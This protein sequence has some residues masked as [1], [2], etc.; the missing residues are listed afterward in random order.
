MTYELLI[1]ETGKSFSPRDTFRIFHEERKGGFETMA[2]VHA[3]LRE[4]YGN[5]KRAAMYHDVKD[6]PPKRIGWVIG[7]RN[8]DISHYP[9]D[10]WIQQDWITVKQCD[11]VDLDEVQS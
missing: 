5:S 9:V 4:R 10:H 6:G 1:T 3:Y 7:F 2:D 8:S 11:T